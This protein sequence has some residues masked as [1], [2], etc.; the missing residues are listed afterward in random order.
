[1]RSMIYGAGSLGTIL[2]AYLAEQGADVLLVSRNAAHIEAMRTRGATVTGCVS[3]TVPVQA[4]LPQEI[5]GTFDVIFLMTKQQDNPGT[6]RFLLPYLAPDGAFCCLQ[7]GLPELSLRGIA[8]DERILGGVI[9]WSATWKEPGVS[10]L[11][12]PADSMGFTIGSPFAKQP[13]ALSKAAEILSLAGNV[14]VDDDLLSMRWSK[15][16]VN[17]AISAVSSSLG[18]PCG[19]ATH[20][21]AVQ[22]LTLRVMRECIDVG[23][24]Q[25]VTFRPVSGFDLA[26]E[27]YFTNEE[28][29]QAAQ[30][31]MPV[32]FESIRNA[33]A[34]VLQDLRKGKTSEVQAISGVVCRTGRA[35]GIPTPFNDRVVAVIEGIQ[36][37]ELTCGPENLKE[38]QDLLDQPIS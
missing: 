25:G 10:E 31:K 5:S 19:G 2:G 14:R 30:A 3:K 23:A 33:V 36:R 17:A 26:R 37:G 20:D 6:A 1:M 4:C 22:P 28:E 12:S 11:T 15:L 38:Y 21:P 13:A 7:N 27:L 34:S 24:A 35:S 9:S 29:L 16:L 32:A 18:M 8:E